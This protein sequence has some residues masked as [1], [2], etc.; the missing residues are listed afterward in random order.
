MF[1]FGTFKE[2][3]EHYALT[4]ISDLSQTITHLTYALIRSSFVSIELK[5]SR[6]S[7]KKKNAWS[8]NR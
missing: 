1:F 4:F 5:S 3:V 7:A 2:E 8:Y 6:Q